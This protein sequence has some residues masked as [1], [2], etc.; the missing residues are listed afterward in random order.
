M[1]LLTD[2]CKIDN[3]YDICMSFEEKLRDLFLFKPLPL[4]ICTFSLVLSSLL[5]RICGLNLSLVLYFVSTLF[6]II[7]PC[8]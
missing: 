5:S 8:I 1:N 4:K 7:K 6:D 3:L 2:K